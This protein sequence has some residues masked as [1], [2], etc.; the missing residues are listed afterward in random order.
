LAIDDHAALEQ[1]SETM[2]GSP[3]KMIIIPVKLQDTAPP[4]E[5]KKTQ[6]ILDGLF[7]YFYSAT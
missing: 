1:A 7:S 2:K 3:H 5:F 4:K 6:V